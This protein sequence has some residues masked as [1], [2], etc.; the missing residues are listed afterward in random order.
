MLHR[1]V[2]F[3]FEFRALFSPQAT[4]WSSR[5]QVTPAINLT[6]PRFEAECLYFHFFFFN[7]ALVMFPL[8]L[9]L[10]LKINIAI[11]ETSNGSS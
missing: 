4:R 6:K 8:P 11:K 7:A 5:V 2:G 9:E 3:R 1:A 10:A